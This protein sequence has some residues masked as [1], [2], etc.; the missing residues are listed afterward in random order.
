[1]EVPWA[2]HY[3]GRPDR[4]AEV[5][6]AAVN[7]QFGLGRGG[8]PGNDDSGGLS[9]WYVW[10][11]LGL[12]PV[13][14][15]SLYLINAPSFA[16]AR[17]DLDGR[18]LAI[19]T[20]GLRRAGARRPA[21]V[22][23]VGPVQ[24]PSAGAVLAARSRSPSRRSARDHA[25]AREPSG[26]SRDHR[27]PSVSRARLER[28]PRRVQCPPSRGGD[29]MISNTRHDRVRQPATSRH[30]RPRRSGDL[31]PLRR[32]A[33]PGRGRARPRLHRGPDRH[34]A[35]RPADRVGPA[36]EA[37]GR[38]RAVQRRDRSSSDPEP[39]GDYKVP[40]GRYLAGLTGRLVELFT[41]GVPT[42]AMS[43]Y[44]SPHTIAITDAVRAAEATGL[45]VNVVD[46]RRGGR[47]RRDQRGPLLCGGEPVRSGRARAV[48][49]P[50][51]RRPG[52]GLGLHPTA[53]HRVG[54]GHRRPARHPLRRPVHRSGWPSPTRR[55]T[56]PSSSIRIPAEVEARLAP[57]RV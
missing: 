33:Q 34:L 7:N 36:A 21:A 3:L 52:R 35:D 6:H 38:H 2:Y 30:R 43:L 1:M 31:W 26:W 55:S 11:S 19:D 25:S 20:D 16:H 8:L 51:L 49:L 50:Q 15:Q 24:R 40:D 13:A 17:L 45:P 27:P 29:R 44:L 53:D 37:A 18:E 9:S 32:G 39:V 12:F 14:G 54:R 5:V 23:P 48:G 56:P 10:A 41:D 28:T 4:T 22:R 47:L 46:H 57:P 42:L